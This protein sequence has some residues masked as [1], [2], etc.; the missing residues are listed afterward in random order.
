[1][2]AIQSGR[3]IAALYTPT[4]LLYSTSMSKQAGCNIWLKLE[5]MQPT[6][7]FKIR[8]VGSMC[9]N[10]LA[11]QSAQRLVAIGDTNAA[12]AV[13]Y[14]ARQLGVPATVFVPASNGPV[15]AIRSKIE[16]EGA[17]MVEEGRSIKDAY[18]AARAFAKATDGAVIID[19]ADDAVAVAGNAT[20]VAEINVQLQRREPIVVV[21]PVGSGGLL[22]G[23]ISGLH[24]NLWNHVPVIAVETHNTSTFQRALLLDSESPGAGSKAAATNGDRRSTTGKSKLSVLQEPPPSTPPPSLLPPFEEDVDV[25]CDPKTALSSSRSGARSDSESLS[26]HCSR[27]RVP[28]DSR[29]TEPTVATCLSV[30]SVC[31]KALELSRAHPVVPISISE[32][33][34]AEACRRFLDDHQMLIEVGSAAALSVVG[35]GL[36]HQIIPDLG[37]NSHVVVVVTGGANINFDRLDSYRQRFPYP[38]PIIAKSGQEIFMRMLDPTQSTSIS[39]LPP[40]S[41]GIASTP[42][43]QRPPPPTSTTVMVSTPL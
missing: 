43:Q 34:A 13:A 29:A 38:A 30:G 9:I 4:P 24:Q 22:S 33:M 10:A 19:T 23:L 1:M 39:G 2:D 28:G 5:N 17:D 18:D 16:L 7:S 42:G 37:H 21:A 32:A 27:G 6:Q 25:D 8:G 3:S 40:S 14:S 11:E 20:I 12:L 31:T 35:K 15:P 26:Y 41:N 36:V